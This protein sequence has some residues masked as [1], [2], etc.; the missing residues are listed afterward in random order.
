MTQATP[1]I[2]AAVPMILKRL[3]FSSVV[4]TC[5]TSTAK[6]GVAALRIEARP[7]A[8]CVC[9]QAIKAKGRALLPSPSSA[10]AARALPLLGSL[11]PVKGALAHRMRAASPTLKPARVN[12][13]SSFTATPMK[14]NDPPHS[15]DKRPNRPHSRAVIARCATAIAA[16]QMPVSAGA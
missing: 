5:A 1:A 11:A 3:S 2:P 14:K 16:S 15:R 13:G 12:G 4:K 6:S 8:R 10:R 7:A 9:P